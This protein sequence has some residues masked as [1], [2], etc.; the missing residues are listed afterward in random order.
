MKVILEEFMVSLFTVNVEQF[1]FIS[2]AM[3]VRTM[4]V[5]VVLIVFWTVIAMR[6]M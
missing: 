3:V 4:V 5:R 1:W 6:K 2:S